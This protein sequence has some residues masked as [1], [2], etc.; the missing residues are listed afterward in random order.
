MSILNLE[1]ELT[2]TSHN[3][4]NERKRGKGNSGKLLEA[5]ESANDQS[6]IG[7]LLALDWLIKV[8]LI[9]EN[10]SK[11]PIVLLPTEKLIVFCHQ[12]EVPL[13]SAGDDSRRCSTN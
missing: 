11:H 3:Q 12:S 5:R 7:F 9:M 10:L 4:G 8:W 13:L 2:T 1:P 6:A